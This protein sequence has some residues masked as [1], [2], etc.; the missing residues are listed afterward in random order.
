MNFKKKIIAGLLCFSMVVAVGCSQNKPSSSSDNQKTEEKKMTADEVGGVS[1]K[2]PVKVDKEAGTVTVLNSVNG[3]YFNE[4][5]RHASVFED[6]SNGTKSI[7]TAYANPE[8]FY[9]GLIETGAKAGNNITADNKEVTHVQGD[10]IKVQITWNDKKKTY[11]LNE[12]IK[13]SN[14]K[15]IDFRFGGNLEN[16]KIKNTGCLTCLDS[17]PVEIIS[18]TTYTY[19]A[20]ESRKEVKFTGNADILPKDGTYVAVIYSIDKQK[21]DK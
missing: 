4:A 18:N 9:N 16:A 5:T 10:K 13:D 21:V 14:G 7:F 12:V 11:D 8:Q 6:S 1:L 15:K 2:N 3:K 19:G 17:C 20:V